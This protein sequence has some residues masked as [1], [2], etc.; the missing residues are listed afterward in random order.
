MNTVGENGLGAE[1]EGSGDGLLTVSEASSMLKAHPNSI[2]RWAD[3]GLLPSYRIGVRGD[4]RFHYDDVADF[5]QSYE[6]YERVVTGR[7]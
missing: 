2:R 6:K 3:M 1:T 7:R 5:L 4:R